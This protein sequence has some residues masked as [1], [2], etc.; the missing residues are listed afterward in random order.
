MKR[1]TP[2]ED[3]TASAKQCAAI[4][5]GFEPP[6]KQGVTLTHGRRTAIYG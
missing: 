1:L 2:V 5:A 3:G 6:C 4:I